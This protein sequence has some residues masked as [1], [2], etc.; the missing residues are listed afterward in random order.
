[1]LST[2]DTRFKQMFEWG[3][4]IP[5]LKV[6]PMSQSDTKTRILD[7]AEQLFAR[8]GFHNTSLRTLT[9]LA[10]VNLASVNYHFGSKAVSYTHLTLPTICSV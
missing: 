2:V 3:E 6:D 1:M 9:S 5:Q 7:G 8:E 10:S 4:L